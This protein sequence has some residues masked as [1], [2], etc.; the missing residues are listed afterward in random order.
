MSKLIQSLPAL[1]NHKAKSHSLKRG[2]SRW[3]AGIIRSVMC[4]AV[5]LLMLFSASSS[6]AQSDP[7][8]TPNG[9]DRQGL[10]PF[11]WVANDPAGTLSVDDVAAGRLTTF[12]L[13]QSVEWTGI[14][15][16]VY[17]VKIK[18]DLRAYKE[19]SSF[20]MFEHQPVA[21]FDLFYPKPEGGFGVSTIST[22]QSVSE[23]ALSMQ[24]LALR[25]PTPAE[26]TTVYL[27]I[28]QRAQP[29][30]LD[31]SWISNVEAIE[32]VAHR[33][34]IQGAL[35]GAFIVLVLHN[36][37]V[38]TKTREFSHLYYAMYLVC[39]MTLICLLTGIWTK[40]GFLE[41]S[42]QLIASVN[43]G[44]IGFGLTFMR[45][46]F[47]FDINAPRLDKAA[48]LLVWSAIGGAVAAVSGFESLGYMSS[49]LLVPAA[50][51]VILLGSVTRLRQGY[52]P[53]IFTLIGISVHMA[54]STLYI[55]QFLK[56]LPG[57]FSFLWLELS[58]VWEAMLFSFA[59]AHRLKVAENASKRA[60]LDREVAVRHKEFFLGMVS[61]ELRSPLQSI[62]SA[63]D[64]LES[65]RA[66]P[67]QAEVM[68]R[69][70]RSANELAV[71]LRDMLTL[72]RG[73]TGRMELRPEVFEACELV[74]ESVESMAREAEAKG[75]AFSV[76]TPAEPLFLVADGVRI[77]QLVH[78]LVSNAVKYT[79]HGSVSVT[80]KTCPN[81][82]DEFRIVV[83]DTGPGLP[84][85]AAATVTRG[86]QAEPVL[87]GERR[88]IG[89]AV[90]RALMMQLDGT[91]EVSP[92][93][94]GGTTFELVVPAARAEDRPPVAGTG[95]GRILV[96]DDRPELLSGFAQVCAELG[97]I[98]DTA[99]SAAMALNLLAAHAY[100][101]VLIDL[102]MPHKTGAQMATEVRASGVNRGARLVAMTAGH[103]ASDAELRVFDSV[104]EKPVRRDQLAAL[105]QVPAKQKIEPFK[106]VP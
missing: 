6:R 57:S 98:C 5:C 43:A 85:S 86:L 78:N 45:R 69:I 96:V 101:A 24:A 42:A 19:A 14:K 28:E 106:R 8:F 2:A 80:L 51:T 23:R 7:V 3:S 18:V 103:G 95:E 83:A 66:S 25:L 93:P 11:M 79:D 56:V 61:H 104:L 91:V 105:M 77:G 47:R 76:V 62:V 99:S 90:V 16:D 48:Q 53:A 9:N 30:L 41:S 34:L 100:G 54:V 67:E 13:L 27:R 50:L 72:A 65:K 88:G 59:L 73:Q 94:G 102:D 89:L 12:R 26:P 92:T 52:E 10:G 38:L 87:F 22:S 58:A 1:S 97:L 71:Q 39:F 64:V 81:G 36:L 74:Q 31:L 40:I 4:V 84:E 60:V 32:E 37:F 20:L 75:L 46:L 35:F 44:V 82:T 70:R 17:W 68:K 55:L 33:Q 49:A 63:L 29:V 15:R 21:R